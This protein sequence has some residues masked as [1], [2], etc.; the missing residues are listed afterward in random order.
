MIGA[1]AKNDSLIL[2]TRPRASVPSHGWASC[3][4]LVIPF[5]TSGISRRG[6]TDRERLPGRAEFQ[7]DCLGHIG[8][9]PA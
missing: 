2:W 5:H 1:L 8:A 7:V 4:L 6:L 9:A 3:Q